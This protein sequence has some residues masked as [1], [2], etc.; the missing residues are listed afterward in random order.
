VDGEFKR[1]GIELTGSAR[2]ENCAIELSGGGK[3][4]A[5]VTVTLCPSRMYF[6][7]SLVRRRCVLVSSGIAEHPGTEIGYFFFFGPQ[8]E[9][10]VGAFG[11][12]LVPSAVQQGFAEAAKEDREFIFGK[13]VPGEIDSARLDEIRGGAQW[14]G[15]TYRLCTNF[16]EIGH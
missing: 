1:I 6:Q 7:Q 5:R 16:I 12:M 14:P 3:R 10:D 15:N 8:L 2:V 13:F 11:G 9:G 4:A